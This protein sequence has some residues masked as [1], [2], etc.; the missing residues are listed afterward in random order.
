MTYSTDGSIKVT[1]N[2]EGTTSGTMEWFYKNQKLVDAE[3]DDITIDDGTLESNAQKYTLTI[4]NVNPE[5]N[6][7]EYKCA[8][9]FSD[10]D[11]LEATTDVEVRK[12]T[13]IDTAGA[14]ESSIVV[15]DGTMSARCLFE[16]DK[17]PSSVTWSKGGSNIEFDSLKKIQNTNTKQLDN[18]IKFFSNITLKE[19]AFADQGSYTCTFVFADGN[20]VEA[21]V[22]AISASI[23][24]DECVFVDYR[25]ESSKALTCTYHGSDQVTGVSFTMPDNTAQTGQLGAYAAGGDADTAGTQTGTYTVTGITAASSGAYTCTFT[26]SDGSTVSAIQRLTARSKSL[27]QSWSFYSILTWFHF[28]F[29]FE[30]H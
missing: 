25:T 4:A 19:F 6:S 24:N 22:N 5:S 16:G 1:C 3:G 29:S 13:A 9:S 2:Y 27:S 26:L 10:G 12:A 8:L 7:G 14:A 17:V 28:N 11:K 20:N 23:T 21:S 18:S 30:L 15:S